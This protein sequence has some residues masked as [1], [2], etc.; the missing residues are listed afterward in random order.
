MGRNTGTGNISRLYGYLLEKLCN[1]NWCY[2]S[3]ATHTTQVCFIRA[4]LVTTTHG[5]KTKTEMIITYKLTMSMVCLL[6]P[7]VSFSSTIWP[8]GS[9][10]WQRV[11]SIGSRKATRL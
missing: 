1:S 6:G 8:A 9:I 5:C 10:M 11:A 4:L 2:A 7:F 3:N